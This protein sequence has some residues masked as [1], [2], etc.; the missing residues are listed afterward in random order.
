MN[1]TNPEAPRRWDVALVLFGTSLVALVGVPVYGYFFAYEPWL[2]A[3]FV[4][5]TLWNGLSITAGYHRL[6][7]HKSFEA[8]WLVR[9]GFALGGA[10]A[11]QN[12]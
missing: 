5:F 9:L 2:W 4:V 11:L 3:G 7:S 12:S 6:W 8:H 10:L 1:N